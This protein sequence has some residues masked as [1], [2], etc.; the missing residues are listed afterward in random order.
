V[1]VENIDWFSAAG[2]DAAAVDGIHLG[3]DIGEKFA[4]PLVL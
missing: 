1:G 2:Q 4:E 3:C